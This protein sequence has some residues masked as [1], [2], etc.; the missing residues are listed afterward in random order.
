MNALFSD[1]PVSRALSMGNTTKPHES[2]TAITD[3]L[4]DVI[5]GEHT[6][7]SGLGWSLNFKASA[8]EEQLHDST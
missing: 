1:N 7:V 6:L 5:L 8:E 2:V 4:L 3:K